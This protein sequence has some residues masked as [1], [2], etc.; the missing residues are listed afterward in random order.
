MWIVDAH[1]LR[2]MQ[3]ILYSWGTSPEL[4]SG[5]SRNDPMV[6]CRITVFLTDILEKN[7]YMFF[8]FFWGGGGYWL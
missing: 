7:K 1:R 6:R 8:V 3:T 4:E 2:T 5:I